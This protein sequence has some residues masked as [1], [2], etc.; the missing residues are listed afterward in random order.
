MTAVEWLEKV[1]KQK[2][3]GHDLPQWVI[4]IIEEA[5]QVEKEQIIEAHFNG[6][7]I[8]EMFNNEKRA[9][10]TDSKQ[11]YNETFKSE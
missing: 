2:L 4:D 9:F 3:I 1:F 6:C 10:I 7:E 11:Y 5:K 8:G